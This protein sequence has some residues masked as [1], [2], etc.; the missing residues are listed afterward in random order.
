MGGEKAPK[1]SETSTYLLIRRAATAFDERL[2][3][4]RRNRDESK[5]HDVAERVRAVRRAP[6]AAHGHQ[7]EDER[8]Q[9]NEVAGEEDLEFEVGGV[10]R[11]RGDFGV[12]EDAVENA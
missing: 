12:A 7:Q 9:P 2:E 8:P 11:R 1:V 10:V 6:A 5:G 4:L 3:N